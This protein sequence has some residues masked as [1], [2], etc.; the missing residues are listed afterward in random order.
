M[1][2]IG[3]T[4]V[5]GQSPVK[6]SQHSIYITTGNLS[7]PSAEH[8][9]IDESMIQT[10]IEDLTKDLIKQLKVILE[11]SELRLYRALLLYIST[12]NPALMVNLRV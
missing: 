7:T 9:L 4:K 6:L 10:L 2:S 11:W 8:I 3:A 1:L 5:L 12:Q